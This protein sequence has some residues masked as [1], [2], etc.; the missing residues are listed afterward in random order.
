ML[1]ALVFVSKHCPYCRYFE[2]VVE[3]L[4]Q[5]LNLDFE[6]VDVD[7]MRE[8]AEKYNVTLIPTLVL[9]KNDEAVGGIMG[10]AD[11]N[12]AL[13]AIKDQISDYSS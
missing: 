13:R 10:Y 5:E 11:F 4:R 8:T 6:F 2:R 12:T 3:K 7:E 9:L 1:K